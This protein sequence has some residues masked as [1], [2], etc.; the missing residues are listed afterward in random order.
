MNLPA[1]K[2]E[3]A[4][5]RFEAEAR[6]YFAEAEALVPCDSL[7]LGDLIGNHRAGLGLSL[8]EFADRAGFTKQ[9]AWVM[10]QGRSLNPTVRTVH[11][12]A[13]ALGLPATLVFSAALKGIDK[14]PVTP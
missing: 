5:R 4:L 1:I 6:G 14:P 9:H 2:F 10:E 3:D 7:S 8:Q 11:S 13:S 12:I